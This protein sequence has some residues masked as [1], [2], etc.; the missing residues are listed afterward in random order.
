MASAASHEATASLGPLTG[1]VA[2]LAI[3]GPLAVAALMMAQDPDLYYRSIQ[4]DEGIEWATFWAFALA[5]LAFAGTALRQR[6]AGVTFPWFQ[7]GLALF[8]FFVAMEEISWAQRVV[9]YRPPSYFLEHNFQQELN[10][11]NVFATSLRKLVLKGIILGY[12]VLLPAVAL[13]APV[14][15]QL[16]RFGISAPPLAL[17]PGF[18][19]TYLAYEIYPWT[20]T[21]EWVE[22]M[23]GLGFVF[24][25]VSTR[26]GALPLRE[27]PGIVGSWMLVLVLGFATTAAFRAIHSARPEV[28]EV[29]RFEVDALADDF[30]RLAE[31]RCGLHKRVYTFVSQYDQEAVETGRFTGLM[32]QGLPE[33]RAEFFLD[34]WNSPYWVRHDCSRG[35]REQVVLVYSFGPNRRRDSTRTELLGDDV[36]VRI[37]H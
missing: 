20:H 8:C 14:R 24:T 7:A 15:T 3:A 31:T 36:G 28:L 37:E 34:P 12:G 32:A 19:V 30:T 25:A 9:G 10:V 21:G 18:L 13:L 5:S 1:L 4:E 23:L 17:A 6:A 2:N 11:H 29:A 27:L 22:Y 33:E 26:P 16:S 35:R